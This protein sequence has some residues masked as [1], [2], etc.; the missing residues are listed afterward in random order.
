MEKK[1]VSFRLEEELIINCKKK[2][3]QEGI[4]LTDFVTISLRNSLQHLDLEDSKFNSKLSNKC[5]TQSEKQELERLIGKMSEEYK[6]ISEEYNK[7]LEE[8]KDIVEGSMLG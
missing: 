1:L 2:A 7:K 4:T 8:V 3:R 6:I 5:I